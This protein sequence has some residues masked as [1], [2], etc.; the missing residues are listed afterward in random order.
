[1]CW[2]AE[3][4]KT[5]SVIASSDFLNYRTERLDPS[6]AASAASGALGRIF[7]Q[8]HAFGLRADRLR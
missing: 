3:R 6:D 8:S 7:A 5:D 2:A 1:M 4:Q